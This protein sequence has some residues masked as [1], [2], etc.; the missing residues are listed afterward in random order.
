MTQHILIQSI[1]CGFLTTYFLF[2]N[3]KT[4]WNYDGNTSQDWA[5]LNPMYLGC[6][7]GNQQSPINI[8]TKAVQQGAIE[9]NLKYMPAKGVN[10]R[11]EHSTFKVTY[12]QGSFLEMVGIRYHLKE[13]HFKTPAENAINSLYAPIEVQ[14][15]H[16]HSKGNKIIL[17]VFFMEGRSNPTLDLIVKNLPTQENK[18]HFITNID[19]NS[20]IPNSLDSYQFDGSL[21]TPPCTQ[22][23]RW[24]VI[25]QPMSATQDQADAMRNIT[26]PNARGTQDVANRLIAE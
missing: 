25:K 26:K 6:E 17:S 15:H 22:G 18:S 12:P 19:A 21:T 16:Q 8:V 23:V 20:F 1:I 14:F 11:L 3:N 9:F 4:E 2:A 13:I 5:N 24:I 10:V 7:N